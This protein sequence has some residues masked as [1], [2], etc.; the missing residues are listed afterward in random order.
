MADFNIGIVG[1]VPNIHGMAA[2][3]YMLCF[4]GVPNQYN[5]LDVRDMFYK[6]L[7]AL[8]DKAGD[9]DDV[10]GEAFATTLQ[11][12]NC[13]GFYVRTDIAICI[14]A[15]SFSPGTDDLGETHA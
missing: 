9:Y 7:K 8:D 15:G 3:P 14:D 13:T 6:N 4:S 10:I 5:A 12:L 2:K 1:D 11:Q